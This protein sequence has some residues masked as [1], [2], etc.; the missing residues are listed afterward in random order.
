MTGISVRSARRSEVGKRGAGEVRDAGVSER[1]ETTPSA[2]WLA[3]V[4]RPTATH[5]SIL[6]VPVQQL[7]PASGTTDRTIRA[8]RGASDAFRAH[9]LARDAARGS[10][11]SRR[12]YSVGERRRS[13]SAQKPAPSALAEFRLLSRCRPLWAPHREP[14]G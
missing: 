10:R 11:P 14:G 13:S 1:A 2:L 12:L 9:A 5:C 4:T 3:S 6:R 8:S 7:R